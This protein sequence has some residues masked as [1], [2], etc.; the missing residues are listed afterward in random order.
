MQLANKLTTL[1]VKPRSPMMAIG[2]LIKQGVFSP[3]EAK[4]VEG[5]RKLRNEVVH[6]IVDH[7]TA[8]DK[9]AVQRLQRITEKLQAS[10]VAAQAE[11]A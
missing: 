2:E 9:S 6:G 4:E 1:T 10:L 7:K 11:D 5:L 3:S 8:V